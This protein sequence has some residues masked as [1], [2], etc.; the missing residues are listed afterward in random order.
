[1]SRALSR[2]QKKKLIEVNGKEIGIHD[3]DGVFERMAA[4]GQAALV[5]VCGYSGIGKSSLVDALRKPIVAK[6][7]Y[8]IAGKFDQYQRDPLVL[9][10]D[11]LQWIDAAHSVRHPHARVSR[12][13]A[14]T[15][16]RK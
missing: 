10:L 14:A 1:V 3:L 6:H 4:T 2:L 5:S 7:G 11:D 15:A 8:F 12:T 16:G 9:F 13:D